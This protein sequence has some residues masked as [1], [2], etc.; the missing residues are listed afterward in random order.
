MLVAEAGGWCWCEAGLGSRLEICEILPSSCKM[1]CRVDDTVETHLKFELGLRDEFAIFRQGVKFFEPRPPS[2]IATGGS[3]RIR[4]L[5][6]HAV[7]SITV[8]PLKQPQG[9]S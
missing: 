5:Q 7:T 1:R 4:H 6:G 2:A 8:A 9:Y 3:L